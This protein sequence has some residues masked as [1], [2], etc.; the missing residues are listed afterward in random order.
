[1]HRAGLGLAK[2]SEMLDKEIFAL[3]EILSGHTVKHLF[4][5]TA[6]YWVLRMI[7]NRQII[8]RQQPD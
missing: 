2:G 6:I 4:V 7:R 1:M 8:L 5:A 3:G